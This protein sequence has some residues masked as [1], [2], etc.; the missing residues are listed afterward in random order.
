MAIGRPSL[1]DFTR[2]YNS[3][4]NITM[5]MSGWDKT[6]VQVV[7]PMLGTI[8]IY[9]TNDGSAIEGVRQG[10]ASLAINF[11]PIQATNLATGS[12]VNTISGTGAYKVDINERFLRLQ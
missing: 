10:D 7:A 5:D 12:A 4:Y 6:T 9:G 11:N 8:F 1:D 3:T 2:Q